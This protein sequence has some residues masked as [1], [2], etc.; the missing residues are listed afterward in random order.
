ML[1]RCP[2]ILILICTFALGACKTTKAPPTSERLVGVKGMRLSGVR[3][4]MLSQNL[5]IG[6]PTFIRI[7]KE[8][9]IIETWIRDPQTK[10][11]APYK[12]FPICKFSGD[13]GP[14]LAEGDGQ[15]P[16]GFYE[17]G[18]DQLNPW[19]QY[20]LSFNLGFPNK[21]DQAR[22]RTGSNLMIH[23]GCES[24]GC[25]AVTDN[26]ME[27]LYLMTEAAISN[28]HKVPVHIFPFKMTPKRM[29]EA[30]GS[31][32]YPEWQNLQIGYNIFESTKIPPRPKLEDYRY[33]FDNDNL[34]TALY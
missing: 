13:L 32:W 1:Q 7:F 29:F 16:E 23:G 14:K 3:N 25:Y 26:A 9:R 19:S 12:Q 34:K 17:V 15:A 5:Q 11:F 18:V 2:I 28:G 24:I 21:Y 20:H 31:Q 4:E 30:Q 22:M 10:Q 8:E 6:D 27:E 33:I